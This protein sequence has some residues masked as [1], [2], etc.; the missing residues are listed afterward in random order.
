[1]RVAPLK[2]VIV[3][4]NGRMGKVLME[5]VLT[6]PG[7][8]LHA[9]VDRHPSK[10]IAPN[11]VTKIT[12]DLLG[13]LKGADIVIDFT[14]PEGTLKHIALCKEYGVK[15]I[16]GTTG[17]DKAGKLAIRTA[18]EQIGIVFAANFSVGINLTFKLLDLATKVLHDDYDIEI[19]EAH[20]RHKVDA[21]SGTA[22]QMG[23][24]IANALGRDLKECAVY[25]RSGIS[26]ERDPKTIGF[27]TVRGGDIIG[28]HTASFA[29]I[30]ERLEISHK[31]SSR[32]SFASGALR[33]AR[34]IAG[35]S[36]GLYSMQDVLDL[37]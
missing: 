21:P 19:I 34:W 36:H 6:T 31:A 35:K 25:G 4:A 37:H 28:E 29:T 9:A 11:N 14:R 20:H 1:M 16:I 13:A 24:I 26:G 8:L 17:F 12:G 15:M 33:A 32:S 27:A 23:E 5:T 2:L 22:L 7:V 30:G 3:G 18:A 10:C